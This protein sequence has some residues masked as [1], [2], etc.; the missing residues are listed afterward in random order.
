MSLRRACALFSATTTLVVAPF[1][2]AEVTAAQPG[3]FEVVEHATI[4]A[5]PDRVWQALGRVGAWWSPEHNYS[6]DARNLSLGLAAGDCLCERW[7]S[8]SVLH[9]T[10]VQAEPGKLLRLEGALGPLGKFGVAGHMTIAI[11]PAPQGTDITLTYDVGGWSKEGLNQLA[12]PVDAVLSEQLR[13][14]ARYVTDGHG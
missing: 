3:G 13:R 2:F 11:K 14:L 4:S 10:V 6:G 12:M 7:G 8:S 5:S 1:A 9:M